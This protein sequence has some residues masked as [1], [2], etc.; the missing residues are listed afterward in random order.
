MTKNNGVVAE[1]EALLSNKKTKNGKANEGDSASIKTI[2]LPEM[3]L[4]QVKFHIIGLAPLIVN[5]FS[6]KAKQM[7]LDKQT[8]KASKGHAIKNPDELYKQSVYWFQ[9]GK[10]SGFPAVGFKAAMTRAGKQLGLAMTDTRGK[11]HILPDEGDLV[12]IR[13]KVAMRDDMVRLANNS[14]DIR[15]RGVYENW[16]ATVTVLFNETSISEE[17]IAQLLE[18][19]GF[20]CGI[21]EWR[22]EKSNSGRY[23]LFRLASESEIKRIK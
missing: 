15:F 17:Q 22:P 23:G 14:A 3:K 5:Q 12:E 20:S 1:A 11:F 8:K 16:S 7:I 10:R 6:E 9:N 4:R 19:A 21:G 13:G 18:N 2:N